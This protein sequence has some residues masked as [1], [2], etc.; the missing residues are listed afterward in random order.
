MTIVGRRWKNGTAYARF[1]CTT[2]YSRGASICPNG[3]SVSE[4]RT[5]RA[6]VDALKG[7][8]DRPH[9][10]ER[11]VARFRERTAAGKNDGSGTCLKVEHSV[12]D[13]ERRIA[14]LTEALAKVGWSEAVAS[15][16][17]LEEAALNRLKLEAGRLATPGPVR[18]SLPS[19]AT[20]AGYLK[21]LL[22]LLETDPARG[23]EL[24]SR[25]VAP[26]VMNPERDGS[27]R[28]YRATGAFDLSF[29]L[30][31]A[32]SG[33]SRS[34]K[35]GCAGLMN[36]PFTSISLDFQTALVRTATGP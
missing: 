32:A 23:R 36:L 29:L 15:K 14:N 28:V 9:L 12:R 13:S 1:G 20:I 11:F 34:G 8:L 3:L 21:G 31:A 19:A 27:K 7:K 35:S 26:V 24:L 30:T 33:S 18:R 2:H 10:V 17:R 25:F 22:A 5:S 4:K 6:L 16:L